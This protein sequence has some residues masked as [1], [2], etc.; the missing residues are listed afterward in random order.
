MACGS[1]TDSIPLSLCGNH[2]H[3]ILKIVL[4]TSQPGEDHPKFV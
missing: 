2:K 1:L 4:G 3:R